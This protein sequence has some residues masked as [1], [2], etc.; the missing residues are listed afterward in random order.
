M[1]EGISNQPR[2]ATVKTLADLMEE[3]E[4][5]EKADEVREQLRMWHAH[6]RAPP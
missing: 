6:K 4:K 1:P 3:A 5:C 2:N